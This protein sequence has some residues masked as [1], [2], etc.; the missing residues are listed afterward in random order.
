MGVLGICWIWNSTFNMFFLFGCVEY[1]TTSFWHGL[2]NNA[3][4]LCVFGKHSLAWTTVKKFTWS[5]SKF[6]NQIHLYTSFFTKYKLL[7]SLRV[8]QD[9]EN[10]NV[11]SWLTQMR[12]NNGPQHPNLVWEHLKTETYHLL[13]SPSESKCPLID[14]D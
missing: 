1:F 14:Y 7:Y 3:G 11:A 10:V 6:K 9:E 4:N 5:T 8:L 2:R 13:L 12:S